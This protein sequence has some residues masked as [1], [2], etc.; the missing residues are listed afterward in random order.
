MQRLATF[1]VA[2][3]ALGVPNAASALGGRAHAV[4]EN[5]QHVVSVSGDYRPDYDGPFE[6][7]VFKRE[8][9]GVCTAE[10]FVP[11][12]PLPFAPQTNGA[13]AA[14]VTLDAPSPD[15]TYRYTPY[16]VRPDGTFEKM[17]WIC[18]TDFRTYALV[19]CGGTPLVRGRL[20][21]LASCTSNS[22]FC[23]T[24]SPCTE[25]CWTEPLVEMDLFSFA[26]AVGP[27]GEFVDQV[28][29]VFGDRTA[30]AMP[31]GDPYSITRIEHAPTGTCGPVPVQE[32]NWGSLKATYR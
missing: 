20:E 12:D 4:C 3:L 15:V 32:R 30:C 24:I 9:I 6:G 7:I 31:N 21:I 28:V 23:V 1:L 25:D 13:F 11:P 2:M 10:E 16:G 26:D 22:G 18:D 8:A 5:G 19:S 29:D 27:F 14:A 17:V